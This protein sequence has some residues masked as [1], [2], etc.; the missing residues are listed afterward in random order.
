M[1][2]CLLTIAA[3]FLLAMG[4]AQNSGKGTG[5]NRYGHANVTTSRLAGTWKTNVELTKRLTGRTEVK[6]DTVSFIADSSALQLI[7]EEKQ[8]FFKTH[9]ILM[10]GYFVF[11]NKKA[12]FILTED[13]GNTMLVYFRDKNGKPNA[14]AESF[15]LFVAVSGDPK[16]DLLHTG[17]D[18]NNQP[19]RC[20]DRIN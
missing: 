2:N 7:P 11:K 10:T 17:G 4:F 3:C 20:W 5:H 15:I 1:K 18:F 9:T 14:D 6:T 12:P 13:K 8:A 19:F 16:N